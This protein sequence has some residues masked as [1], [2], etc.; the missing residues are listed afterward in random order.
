[1]APERKEMLVFDLERSS[2]SLL[3]PAAADVSLPGQGHLA[4]GSW[5]SAKPVKANSFLSMGSKQNRNQN[6]RG[7][8]ADTR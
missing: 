8:V 1:M 5:L 7:L 2:F 4:V 6:E 3:T